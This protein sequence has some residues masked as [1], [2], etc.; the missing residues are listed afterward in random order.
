MAEVVDYAGKIQKEFILLLTG[1]SVVQ[2]GP[3]AGA[4]VAKVSTVLP[5]PLDPSDVPLFVVELLEDQVVNS[6]ESH[7]GPPF[8]EEHVLHVGVASI[9]EETDV[10]D[11][12]LLK[13]KQLISGAPSLFGPR[14]LS[15]KYQ[16]E[17]EENSYF[18]ARSVFAVNFQVLGNSPGFNV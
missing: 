11:Q 7:D 3:P 6:N 18:V 15:T 5:R 9:A 16:E 13:A 4:V 1:V 14:F 8:F 2:I 17:A 12:M 10:R